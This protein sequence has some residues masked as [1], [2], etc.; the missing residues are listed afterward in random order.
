MY[1]VSNTGNVSL[2]AI[3]LQDLGRKPELLPTSDE[4]RD[5]V[6]SPGETWEFE[7]ES[8]F[9]PE[10]NANTASATATTLRGDAPLHVG[11]PL[12]PECEL[13]PGDVDGDGFVEFLD[14]LFIAH[15]FGETVPVSTNGDLD[16]NGL[17]DFRDFLIF[18]TNFGQAV[19]PA[20]GE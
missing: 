4:G 18:A 13:N 8:R 1:F 11:A 16:C 14:F 17:V 19:E 15:H 10:Q 5:A 3:E 2:H 20:N 12:Q 7:L 6:L 9:A